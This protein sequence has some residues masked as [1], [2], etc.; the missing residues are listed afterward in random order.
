MYLRWLLLVTLRRSH[1]GDLDSKFWDST[2]P[3]LKFNRRKI[4]F[5]RLESNRVGD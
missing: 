3:A 4:P 2:G 1:Q 5:R